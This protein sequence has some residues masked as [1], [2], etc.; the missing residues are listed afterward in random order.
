MLNT[1][2]LMQGVEKYV[3]SGAIPGLRSVVW[4]KEDQPRTD[5][6]TIYLPRPNAAWDEDALLLWRYKAEHELGHEDAVN[7]CPHWREVMVE[8]KKDPKYKDDGLLWWISNLLSDHVQEHNRVGDMVGRDAILYNGRA[9]FLR[10]VF[11]NC[12]K[13]LKKAADPTTYISCGLFYWDTR[14]R[15]SWND[16]I[17]L[18]GGVISNDEVS[19]VVDK[20]DGCGVDPTILKN[21]MDVFNAAVIIRKL[22][23]EI[24]PQNGKTDKEMEKGEARSEWMI[25]K[26]EKLIPSP[27]QED[28]GKRKYKMVGDKDGGYSPRN[29]VGVL[30]GNP[31]LSGRSSAHIEAVSLMLRKTNLPAKVR[32]FLMAMKREK[33]DNGFRSGRLDTGRLTNALRNR[34]DLFR[35]KEE[36]HLVN[37][38]V[39]LL[40][41]SSGSMYGSKFAHAC[42]SAC[43]LAEALQGIGVNVEIAGFTESGP[44]DDGLVHDIWLPFGRRY[45]RDNVL[46]KMGKMSESLLN[47]VD[48]E[49]ILYAYTRLKNQ[50]ETRKILIVLSDGSPAGSGPYG[51]TMGPGLFT[52]K[53][54]QDIEKDKHVS[55]VGIGI[56]GHDTARL[57]KN[58]V[59]VEHGAPMEPALL[60]VV[61]NAVI[62]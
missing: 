60:E 30:S 29:P 6:S 16:K 33:W 9:M 52:L 38:A 17:T 13:G 20:L 4:T 2:E 43:M 5:G 59:K 8:K 40:V 25:D 58:S 61:K 55:I 31:L 54:I 42:A 14:H 19:K 28:D 53:V 11:D 24:P 12:V 57:Y 46:K 23:D 41:D 10:G 48:G 3:V 7:S 27:H 51:N 39:S 37:S 34:E 44:G 15:M 45:V 50:K 56:G 47:N 35:R 32:A 26:V 1:Y 22:F 36:A 18:P 49:N 21:E 62:K